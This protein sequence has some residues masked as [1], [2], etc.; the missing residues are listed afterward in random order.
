MEAKNKT[1]SIFSAFIILSISFFFLGC[2]NLQHLSSPIFTT[3]S[4]SHNFQTFVIDSTL[5]ISQQEWIFP[6]GTT[7]KNK[8]IV[9]HYFEKKGIYP[10]KLNYVLN[11]KNMSYTKEININNDS[12]YYQ[13]GESAWWLEEFEGNTLDLSAWNYDIGSNKDINRWGNNEW[14]NYTASSENSFL[15]DG[16]LVIRAKKI[17]E[18]QKVEDYTSARL[19]T[20]AKKEINSGRVEIKAKL[21]GGVGLWPAAW[22][23]QSRGESGYY[24]ELDLMEYVGVDKNIVYSAIHTNHTLSN[25]ENRISGNRTI[26]NVENE[27]HIFGMNWTDEKVEFYIDAPEKPHLTFVPKN[28]ENPDEWPFSIKKLYIILNIAVGGDWG[29]MKGVDDSIFPKEME[30]DYVRIFRKQ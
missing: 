28:T 8:K 21:A 5:N 19:T 11:G 26:D 10:V 13:N 22:L 29:G 14:Q 1:L 12:F 18:G 2:K 16:K 25:S 4:V 15:R 24:S 20:K 6:D 9:T 30:V 3:I 27:F 23:Y 7:I 17:G